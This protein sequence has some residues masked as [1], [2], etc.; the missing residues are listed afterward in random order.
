MRF[1]NHR[2]PNFKSRGGVGLVKGDRP[3]SSGYYEHAKTSNY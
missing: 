3:H 1:G 2:V